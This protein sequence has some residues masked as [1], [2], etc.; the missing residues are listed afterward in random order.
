MTCDLGVTLEIT[1]G[2]SATAL[3]YI[4]PAAC[5]LKL[6]SARDLR[7]TLSSW[8]SRSRSRSKMHGRPPENPG[9]ACD[10][11]LSDLYFILLF[12]SLP[13]QTRSHLKRRTCM[14]PEVSLLHG[15]RTAFVIIFYPPRPPL[16]TSRSGGNSRCQSRHGVKTLERDTLRLAFLREQRRD[17]RG[18]RP[19]AFYAWERRDSRRVLRRLT[20]KQPYSIESARCCS[21]A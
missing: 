19:K 18:A 2:I 15:P 3:A 20:H 13:S 8:C 10:P 1:G 5:F 9:F 6:S 16:V 17:T 7:T 12:A 14:Y 11:N 4:F 21:Y